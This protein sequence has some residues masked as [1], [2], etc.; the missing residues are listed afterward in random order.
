[1]GKKKKEKKTQ[2]LQMAEYQIQIIHVPVTHLV[3]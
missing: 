2:R 3:A 1:M